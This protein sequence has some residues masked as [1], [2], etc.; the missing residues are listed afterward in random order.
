M[1]KEL[2]PYIGQTA[3]LNVENGA[4]G[5]KIRIRDI[6]KVFNRFEHIHGLGHFTALEADDGRPIRGAD[7]VELDAE[8]DDDR[9]ILVGCGCEDRCIGFG[10]EGAG[11]RHEGRKVSKGN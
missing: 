6:R 3:L 11:A 9:I 8:R 10:A 7:F 4:L 1:V 5:I 2:S